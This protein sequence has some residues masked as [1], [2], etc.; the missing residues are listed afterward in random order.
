MHRKIEGSKRRRGATRTKT[1]R[2]SGTTVVIKT[3]SPSKINK[4]HIETI[5]IKPQ[6]SNINRKNSNHEQQEIIFTAVYW[7]LWHRWLT[8]CLEKS[9]LL[10]SSI[11]A[12]EPQGRQRC[13][14]NVS[15]LSKHDYLKIDKWWYYETND[16]QMKNTWNKK[17]PNFQSEASWDTHNHNWYLNIFQ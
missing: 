9:V 5:H 7:H 4:Q 1:M 10:C 12:L 16:A 3:N 14:Q 13:R 2:A 17:I 11:M 6:T 8:T 15:R